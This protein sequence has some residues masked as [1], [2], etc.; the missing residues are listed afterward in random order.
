MEQDTKNIIG[1]LLNVLLFPG[2]GTIL[3]GEGKR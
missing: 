1:L 3:H 2:L